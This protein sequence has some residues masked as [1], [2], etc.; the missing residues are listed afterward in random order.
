MNNKTHKQSGAVS[1]FI[2]IFSALL[3]TVITLSFTS[4]MIKDQQQATE[5]DLSQSAYDSALAGV[6]DAKRA[7]IKY[8]TICKTKT[9]DECNTAKATLLSSDCNV[10]VDMLDNINLN[11]DKEV[12]IKTGSADSLNQAYTCVKV[13]LD[14]PDYLGTLPVDSYEM[15][16][17][18]GEANFDKIKIEWFSAND[19]GSDTNDYEVSLLDHVTAQ[20]LFLQ[21]EWPANR[22]PILQAQVVQYSENGFNLANL[23]TDYEPGYQSN[24]NTVFLYPVSVLGLTASNFTEYRLEKKGIDPV[25][26]SKSLISGGYA[27]SMTLTLATPVGGGN[28]KEAYLYIGALYNSTDFKVSML[29]STNK[30]VKFKAVQP[31]VDSNG[32]A[33]DLFR[34]VKARVRLNDA[35]FPYP[36]SALAVKGDLCK[37]FIVTDVDTDFNDYCN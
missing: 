27:C 15:V 35:S 5:A 33:N 25:S 36:T 30:V 37:N 3:I 7:I 16:P 21:K 28:R 1:L 11:G 20:P 23:D 8:E 9:A 6:E 22:P 13:I 26:C 17:L 34:R 24:N 31:E 14:T 10:S 2:V 4:L 18:S 12:D 29:D 32:R 19:L